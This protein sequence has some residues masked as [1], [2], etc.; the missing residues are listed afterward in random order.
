[1]SNS[2]ELKTV[3]L[4]KPKVKKELSPEKK[5]INDL[6]DKAKKGLIMARHDG[7]LERLASVR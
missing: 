7:T 3:T 4:K 5:H 2:A 6:K 1:M